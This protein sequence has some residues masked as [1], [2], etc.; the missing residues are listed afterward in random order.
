MVGRW[1]TKCSFPAGSCFMMNLARRSSGP[2][3]ISVVDLRRTHASVQNVQTLNF[4]LAM[5]HIASDGCNIHTLASRYLSLGSSAQSDRDRSVELL[6]A[7]AAE[8]TSGPM[9]QKGV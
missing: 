3:S 6:T 2:C 9:A 5:A 4:L 1:P 7:L 8:L